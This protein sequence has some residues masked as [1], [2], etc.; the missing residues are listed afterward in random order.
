MGAGTVVATAAIHPLRNLPEQ[1]QR[2]QHES[3]REAVLTQERMMC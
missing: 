1:R 3:E 2:V